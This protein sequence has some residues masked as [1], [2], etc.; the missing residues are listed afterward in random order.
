MHTFHQTLSTMAAPQRDLGNCLPRSQKL[1]KLSQ[2]NDV[3]LVGH[4]FRQKYY[5]LQ[6]PPTFFRFFELMLPLV[7]DPLCKLSSSRLD[8][9][10]AGIHT[11]TD[12]PGLT[13]NGVCSLSHTLA[14]AFL[15]PRSAIDRTPLPSKW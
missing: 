6:N 2:K 12:F 15:F 4:T 13:G 1:A 11:G 7:G 9:P 5:M 8:Q 14:H 3:K 10:L